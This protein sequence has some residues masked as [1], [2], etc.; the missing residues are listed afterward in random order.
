MQLRAIIREWRQLR[1]VA[2]LIKV[3]Q[4]SD[5]FNVACFLL[6]KRRKLVIF[7]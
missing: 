4:L 7:S 1:Y 3:A 5:T 2:V 6:L